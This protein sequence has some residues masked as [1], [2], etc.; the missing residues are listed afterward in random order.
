MMK[1]CVNLDLKVIGFI[2]KYKASGGGGGVMGRRLIKEGGVEGLRPR[3]P[4]PPPS[5]HYW[6]GISLDLIQFQKVSF[7]MASM[8]ITN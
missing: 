2:W 4:P 1:L 3:S 8:N 6:P 5:F 7:F